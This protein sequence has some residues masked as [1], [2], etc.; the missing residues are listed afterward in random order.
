MAGHNLFSLSTFIF[1]FNQ[2]SSRILLI[3]RNEEKRKKWG[4]DWGIIGGK[5][6]PGEYSVEAAIRETEEEI[7][8]RLDPKELK[9]IDYE[10]RPSQKHTSA[11]HFFYVVNI[12]E[13]SKIIINDESDEYGWFE[14][15]KLPDQMLDKPDTIFKA[16][17]FILNE[18][19]N[20]N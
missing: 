13:D 4:F 5:I 20:D 2:D 14:M 19:K 3:K 17:K 6:D 11:V 9:L 8:L 1:I 16:Q 7:G 10:E 15:D 18:S 12:N